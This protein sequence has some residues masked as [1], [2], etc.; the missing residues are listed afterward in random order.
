MFEMLGYIT[1]AK[2]Y[3]YLRKHA[4][5]DPPGFDRRDQEDTNI[6]LCQHYAR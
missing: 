5:S 3:N 1:Q 2:C 6:L 4:I